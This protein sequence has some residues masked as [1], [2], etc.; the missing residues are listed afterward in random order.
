[1]NH[2]V[3]LNRWWKKKKKKKKQNS[4]N[5]STAFGRDD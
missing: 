4:Y 2:Q 5:M 3:T 1:M